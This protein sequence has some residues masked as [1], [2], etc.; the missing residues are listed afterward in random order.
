MIHGHVPGTRRGYVDGPLG[1]LHY[2]DTGGDGPVLLLLHQSPV[3]SLQYAAAYGPLSAGGWRVIGLDTPGFGMSDAPEEV[4]TIGTYAESALALLDAL[5]VRRAAVLGHHTG[6]QVAV[7]LAARRPDRVTAVVLAGPPYLDDAERAA[8]AERVKEVPPPRA[9][10]SHLAEA[11]ALRTAPGGS[12]LE[13]L[14]R[15][16][17]DSL[18]AGGTGWHGH[19]AAFAYDMA[20]AVAAARCP[21]LVVSN[22]GDVLHEPSLRLVREHPHVSLEVLEG[23]TRDVVDEV[24]EQLCQVVLRFLSAHVDLGG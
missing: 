14:H 6:A 9:D 1:Q 11:W 19:A 15:G 22:T 2:R 13:A 8:L 18:V 4:P 5:G 23:G 24:P 21:I 7:D 16:V 12:T 17:V 20:P 10:G 3:S